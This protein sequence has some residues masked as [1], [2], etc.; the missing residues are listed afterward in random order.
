MLQDLHAR[1]DAGGAL[2]PADG[3]LINGGSGTVITLDPGKTYRIRVS[4]VGI[5]TSLNFRIASHNFTVVETEGSHTQQNSYDNLDI[6]VGQ[7]YS[8]LVTLDQ[9]PG[10]YYI[11]ASSRFT[12]ITLNGTAILRYSNSGGGAPAPF[13]PAPAGEI[14]YSID[15]AKSIRS[16]GVFGFFPVICQALECWLF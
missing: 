2:G 12:Q 3:I 9:A 16:V 6:H 8:V 14:E 5:S 15:Q 4:N 11:V 10:D 13:P 1:L 7:T